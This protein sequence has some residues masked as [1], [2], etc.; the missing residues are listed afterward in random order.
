MD[1]LVFQCQARPGQTV[2]F[3]FHLYGSDKTLDL[4]VRP[5]SLVQQRDGKIT[6]ATALQDAGQVRME[7]PAELRLRPGQQQTITGT[8]TLPAG[9]GQ[10]H[11]VGLMVTDLSQRPEPTGD[12]G[13]QLGVQF[14][15]RYL[16]RLE[17]EIRQLHPVTQLQLSTGQLSDQ[18]GFAVANVMLWNPDQAGQRFNVHARLTD[19]AGHLVMDNIPLGL[20]VRMN[21]PE[22]QR[23]QVIVLPETHVLLAGR[24]PDPVFPGEYQLEVI[25]GDGRSVLRKD[26]FPV[27]V[28]PHHFLAQRSVVARVLKSID[29]QPR[30]IELSTL[31]RGNRMVPLS[32]ENKGTEAVAIQLQGIDPSGQPLSWLNVR[33]ATL[34]LAPGRRRNVMLSVSGRDAGG[35]DHYAALAVTANGEDTKARGVIQLPV[36]WLNATQPVAE[37]LAM[38]RLT[39]AEGAVSTLQLPLANRGT[40]HLTP[41]L[42]L[43]LV[44]DRGAPLRCEAGYHAWVLP[45]QQQVYQFPIPQLHPGRYRAKI[46]RLSERGSQPVASEQTIRIR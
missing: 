14:V 26:R 45:G 35:T 1:P 44:G 30:E 19:V 43:T 15:T 23:S 16:L 37:N 10:F 20:P 4:D 29:I 28:Q 9:N 38:G 22:P 27:T 12:G 7:S 42:V 18:G 11:A 46:E 32:F 36:A 25:V 6:A 31:R 41:H 24:L 39:V 40:R 5:V 17:A 8:W 21:Q 33:P 13:R 2:R 34:S 3:K